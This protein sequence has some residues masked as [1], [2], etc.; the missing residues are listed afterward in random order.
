MIKTKDGIK[1]TFIRDYF[2]HIIYPDC[3]IECVN[4]PENEIVKYAEETW[5]ARLIGG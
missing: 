3:T 2:W 5:R 4:K 1:I